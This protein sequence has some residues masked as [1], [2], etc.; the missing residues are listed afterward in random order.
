M[1][2]FPGDPKP[3]IKTKTFA[4]ADGMTLSQVTIS[5]HTGTHVDV[6]KHFFK[7]GKTI[8]KIEAERL[9][10]PCKVIDLT[11]FFKAGGPAEIGWAHFG[12]SGIKKNDRVLVKTGNYNFLFDKK[13]SKKYISVSQDAAKN[14]IKRQISLIGID[15]ITIEK[16]N[17]DNYPVH[18]LFLKEGIIILE[19]LNLKDV[20]AGEYTL[21]CAPLKLEGCDGSPARVFLIKE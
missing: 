15:Y 4:K 8:D 12:R 5:T 19:G 20:P 9:V 2:V 3:K 14:L 18:K 11:N 6:P 10:G 7:S 21:V 17:K 16:E 13:I 1:L